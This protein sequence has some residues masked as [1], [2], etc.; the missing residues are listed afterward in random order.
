MTATG[1]GK[2]RVMVENFSTSAQ[3]E[4]TK[5]VTNIDE[6]DYLDDALEFAC[7][8]RKIKHYKVTVEGPDGV[9]MDEE[10]LGRRCVAQSKVIWA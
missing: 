8:K 2:W 7:E 6:F 4:L 3:Q 5:P 1:Q 10:E 9:A